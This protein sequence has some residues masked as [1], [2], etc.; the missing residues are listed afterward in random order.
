MAVNLEQ[1][2]AKILKS[3]LKHLAPSVRYY[4]P[5]TI[6]NVTGEDRVGLDGEV[7]AIVNSTDLLF[8]VGLEVKGSNLAS[9][10]CASI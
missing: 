7:G 9:H 2:L 8:Y 6:S 5:L 4:L 1:W 10:Q 3:A